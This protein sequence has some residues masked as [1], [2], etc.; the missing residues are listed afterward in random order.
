MTTKVIQRG[1]WHRNKTGQWDTKRI[2]VS[3][4]YYTRMI[5]ESLFEVTFVLCY[6]WLQLARMQ[7][8]QKGDL[9]ANQLHNPKMGVSLLCPVVRKVYYKQ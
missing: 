3:W 2:G 6:E 4:R 7:G 8:S 1:K 5:R 9:Q